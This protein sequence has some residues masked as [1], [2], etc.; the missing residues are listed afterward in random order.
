MESRQGPIVIAYNGTAAARAAV[1][2]AGR[3]WSGRDAVVLNVCTRVP[4]LAAGQELHRQEAA[5]RVATAGAGLGNEAGLVATPDV[6]V[7]LQE[8]QWSAIV[9]AADRLGAAAVVVGARDRTGVESASLGSVAHGVA[10]HCRCPVL[11]VS[12]SPARAA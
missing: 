1:L 11:I 10:A 8:H 2:E 3:L 5:L 12:E 7:A 4:E 9:D 6:V